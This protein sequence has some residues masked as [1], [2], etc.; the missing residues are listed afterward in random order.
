MD[1]QIEKKSATLRG[2]VEDKLREAI[3]AGV[4]AP[5]QRL[6]ERELCDLLGV[7]RTSVREALRQLEAENLIESLPHKGPVVARL[8]VAEARQLYAL[9]TLLEAHA[10]WCC[11]QTADEDFLR[12]LD[13]AV[14]TFVKA[15]EGK[16][17]VAMIE[18]KTAFYDLLMEGCGNKY[19]TRTL[20]GLHNQI[21]ALRLTSMSRPDRLPR[22][23]AE[24]RAI[25]AAI[26]SGD[27][28]RA[29]DACRR[30][31]ENASEVALAQMM[32]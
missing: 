7:G 22:S 3:A 19:I 27:P 1:L 6:I 24:I 13:A 25:A 15:S 8:S 2:L 4:F 29:E 28:A 17:R 30:H 12:R 10:G 11:A 16:E 21:S 9:R 23:I 20:T 5:G 18:A 32:R 14:E 26:R 31:I